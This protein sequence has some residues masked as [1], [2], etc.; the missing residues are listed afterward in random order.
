[1][2]NYKPTPY[3]S[4]CVSGSLEHIEAAGILVI[5]TPDYDGV[6]LLCAENYWVMRG[7]KLGMRD[8]RNNGSPKCQMA[9]DLS[10]R[11]ARLLSVSIKNGSYKAGSIAQDCPM[12]LCEA[13]ALKCLRKVQNEGT[14]NQYKACED[15]AR[16]VLYRAFK[17]K[18]DIYSLYLSE[19]VVSQINKDQKMALFELRP[20]ESA[21]VCS[22]Y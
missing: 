16:G 17:G 8:A 20:L 3:G 19:G 14:R 4:G 10:A 2:I 12:P 18:V 1:V 15:A 22:F 11:Y 7:S 13:I 9:M 21:E 5:N 6:K